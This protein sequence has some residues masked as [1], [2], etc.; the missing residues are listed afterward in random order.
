MERIDERKTKSGLAWGRSGRWAWLTAAT[1]AAL[2]AVTLTP[3]GVAAA[4]L[5]VPMPD[6]DPFYA[7]PTGIAQLPN[8]TVLDSRP[9]TAKALLVP[10]DAHAWQVKYKTIDQH[11]QPSA[12]VTTVLIPKTAWQGS[13]KR[14]LVSYQTAEDSVGTQ[15]APSY[16]LRA[17]LAAGVQGA[18]TTLIPQILQRGFAVTVPDYQGKLAEFTGAEG[19]ARGVIDGIRAARDFEP[20]GIG[21]SAPIGLVGYSGGSMATDWALHLQ[22]RYA[23]ELTFAGA[24]SGGTVADLKATFNQFNGTVL[25]GGLAVAFVGLQRSYPDKNILQYLNAD[26]RR[27]VADSQHDCLA[28]SALKYPFA[29]ISPWPI[30]WG[31]TWNTTNDP[32]FNKIFADVSLINYPGT[33]RTPILFYHSIFDQLAPIGKMRD[34]FA[35][36]CAEGVTAAKVESIAGEHA[37]YAI[38]GLPTALDYLSDRFDGE[39]APNHC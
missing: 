30:G 31:K 39:P 12:F 17:G 9:I 21:T 34:L 11:D 10:I 7:V 1:V 2:A 19:S 25:G 20:A 5:V 13:G 38:T 3:G 6:D 27:A 23:P 29:N 28:D 18:E 8:G 33:P 36:Y 4:D 22:P 15:C 24:A 35:R 32:G 16:A 14:P 37:A 26:G